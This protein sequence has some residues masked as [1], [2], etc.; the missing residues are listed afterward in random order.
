[1]AEYRPSFRT[2][3]GEVNVTVQDI[4]TNNAVLIVGAKDYTKSVNLAPKREIAR[5]IVDEIVEKMK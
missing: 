5:H 1:M 4:L 2:V 3:S